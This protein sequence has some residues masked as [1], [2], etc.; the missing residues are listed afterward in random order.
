MPV[1]RDLAT[2]RAPGAALRVSLYESHYLTAVDPAGGRAVWLRHTSLKPPGEPARATVWLTSF[3]RAAPAPVALRITAEEPVADPGPAWSRSSLGEIGPGRAA[4]AMGG[5]V[6][7]LRWSAAG[8]EVPYLPARWLYDR[9]FPRSGGVALTPHTAV[10]GAVTLPAARGAPVRP[11]AQARVK[12]EGWDGMVGH[13]WG[14]EHLEHW[15][16]VH[17]GGFGEGRGNWFDLVL[18]RVR[19]GPVLTPWLASGAVCVDGSRHEPARRGRIRLRREGERSWMAVP[20][21]GGEPLRLELT[22]PGAATVHWDYASPSGHGRR[23]EHSSVADAVVGLGGR[24]WELG[25]R[26]SVEIGSP[27]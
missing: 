1:V 13:N 4:G 16:W 14:S 8:A 27:L 2:A 21:I 6:W 20:L 22:A 9:P 10:S 25:A 24:R 26:T 18:A 3:D 5:A 17:A 23:V 12:L 7:E 15:V 19:L 11:G